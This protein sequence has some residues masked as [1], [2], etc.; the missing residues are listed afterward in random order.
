MTEPDPAPAPARFVCP[1][2]RAASSHPD[3][4]RHGYC[5]RC[6]AFTGTPT[7]PDSPPPVS[8][9]DVNRYRP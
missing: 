3:D 8:P 6:H 9:V 2:C 7:D 4:L 1:W 5:G